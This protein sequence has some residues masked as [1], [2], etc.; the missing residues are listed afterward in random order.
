EKIN[1]YNAFE[2]SDSKKP[3]LK[4]SSFTL[5]SPNE[6]VTSYSPKNDVIIGN[7]TATSGLSVKVSHS[8]P[9]VQLNTADELKPNTSTRTAAHWWYQ[10][11]D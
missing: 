1:W 10:R 6:S 8:D 2:N 3:S 7:A 9:A 4:T 11:K 5:Y